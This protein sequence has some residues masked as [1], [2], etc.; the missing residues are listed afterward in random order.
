MNDETSNATPEPAAPT[1]VELA[2]DLR[3]IAELEDQKAAIQAEIDDKTNKL[4]AAIENVDG[5]SLLHQVLTAALLPKSN[6]N[7]AKKPTRRKAS[8]KTTKRK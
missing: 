3:R 2:D 7:A 4:R 5:T 8:K 6:S 1:Q